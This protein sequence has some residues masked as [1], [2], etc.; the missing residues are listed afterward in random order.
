MV[1]LLFRDPC[2]GVLRSPPVGSFVQGKVL[3]RI[4]RRKLSREP[5]DR[6]RTISGCPMVFGRAEMNPDM[7]QEFPVRFGSPSPLCPYF[8]H[9]MQ[10]FYFFFLK[11][12]GGGGILVSLCT[13]SGVLDVSQFVSWLTLKRHYLKVSHTGGFI[14]KTVQAFQIFSSN[15]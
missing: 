7:S 6:Y 3:I 1:P 14:L 10:M 11:I 15:E 9:L 4:I 2:F 13:S 8:F 12:G 5:Q